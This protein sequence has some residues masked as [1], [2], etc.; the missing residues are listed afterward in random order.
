MSSD[1]NPHATKHPFGPSYQLRELPGGEVIPGAPYAPD[2]RMVYRMLKF[3]LSQSHWK[4]FPEGL[5]V[6]DLA[7]NGGFH[8]IKA[9]REGAQDCFFVDMNVESIRVARE[10]AKAWEVHR[11]CTFAEGDIESF[12]PSLM[13]DLVMAHQVIYHLADPI[14]FLRRVQ[15][16]LKPGGV[17]AMYTRVAHSIHPKTHEWVP[18]WNTMI[19]ALHHVGFKAVSFFEEKNVLARVHPVTRDARSG[20]QEKVLVIGWNP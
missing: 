5:K 13:F 12:D 7:C 3:A 15:K 18:S 17:F 9:L 4:N 2:P 11:K 14:G 10:T 16:S 8:G 20:G 6:A 1:A 19:E